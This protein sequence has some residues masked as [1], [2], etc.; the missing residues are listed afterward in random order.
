MNFVTSRSI[1]SGVV[2]WIFARLILKVYSFGPRQTGDNFVVSNTTAVRLHKHSTLCRSTLYYATV[3]TGRW[4]SHPRPAILEVLNVNAHSGQSLFHPFKG[5]FHR[6]KETCLLISRHGM[7]KRTIANYPQTSNYTSELEKRPKM[8]IY[9]SFY[10]DFV[11]ILA[12]ALAHML[13]ILCIL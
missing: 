4:L 2:G 8:G 11:R 12:S 1:T 9:G 6:R 3:A 10:K 5:G 13:R 7:T